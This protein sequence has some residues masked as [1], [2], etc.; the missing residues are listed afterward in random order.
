MARAPPLSRRLNNTAIACRTLLSLRATLTLT[1]PSIWVLY[2]T[3]PI[4]DFLKLENIP[5]LQ[6][7]GYS[8]RIL[9]RGGCWR[10]FFCFPPGLG[11]CLPN[12]FAVTV[13]HAPTRR[14]LFYMVC[15]AF[16]G[17]AFSKPSG[18]CASLDRPFPPNQ[19]CKFFKRMLEENFYG[20]RTRTCSPI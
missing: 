2:E 16:T 15:R 11:A 7:T 3:L 14:E 5:G 13:R 10:R 4:S 8:C 19:L 1:G 12:K 9:E 18:A 17:R 20:Y 6:A